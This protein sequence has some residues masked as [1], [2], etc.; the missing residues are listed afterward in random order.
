MLINMN[1]YELFDIEK[2]TKRQI[3]D[4]LFRPTG[5][6]KSWYSGLYLLDFGINKDDKI[7][8]IGSGQNPYPPAQVIVDKYADDNSQRIGRDCK[9]LSHQKLYTCDAAELPFEDNEFDFVFSSH[10][11]EH[12]TRL[13]EALD[14]MS[15]VGKKGFIAVPGNDFHIMTDKRE[16]GHKWVC[17]YEDGVLKIRKKEDWEYCEKLQEIHEY[18]H[19]NN[20][21]ISEGAIPYTA[22]WEN[23]YRY[24]WEV[25]FVWK[26]EIKYE[27]L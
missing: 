2:P 9:V 3:I 10:T 21:S 12:I 14:E 11:I 26:G 18:L 16:Y 24:I 4:G 13:P 20:V 8:D 27:V 6:E 19:V 5:W 22:L 7:I 1:A 23:V 17:K 15:R 25:R